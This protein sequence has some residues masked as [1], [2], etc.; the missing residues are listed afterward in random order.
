[1]CNLHPSSFLILYP[2]FW[3][4]IN[5][6]RVYDERSSRSLIIPWSAPRD[7]CP[8]C[9]QWSILI[10]LSRLCSQSRSIFRPR[11]R[12]HDYRRL[13][14]IAR[15]GFLCPWTRPWSFLSQQLIS[16]PVYR[17]HSLL[18]RPDCPISESPCWNRCLA[19]RIAE[20]REILII[21]LAQG[22][23]ISSIF[24]AQ[25]GYTI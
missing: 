1:M 16:W 25:T 12:V 10:H 22:Y 13:K 7:T 21:Q 23:L 2:R 15:V 18:L 9:K 11:V 20:E 24:S 6:L 19:L 8:A 3:D 14:F 17:L 4:L 5:R